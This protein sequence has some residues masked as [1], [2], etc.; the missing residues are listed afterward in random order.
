MPVSSRATVDA[1]HEVKKH[2]TDCR[3]AF[4]RVGAQDA[5][6]KDESVK[7]EIERLS[8]ILRGMGPKDLR[9]QGYLG[10]FVG[11]IFRYL[12]IFPAHYLNMPLH[13]D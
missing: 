8:R 9:P 6:T 12:P 10:A 3:E 1:S 4:G 11:N 13:R 7:E 5:E 2:A